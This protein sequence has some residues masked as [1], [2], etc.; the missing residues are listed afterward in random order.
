MALALESSPNRLTKT[1][2][3]IFEYSNVSP[4][5]NLSSEGSSE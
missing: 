3:R 2:P 4:I 5:V 1:D